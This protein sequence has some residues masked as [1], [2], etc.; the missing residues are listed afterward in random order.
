MNVQGAARTAS[1]NMGSSMIALARDLCAFRAAVVSDDNEKLFARI[2]QELPLTMTRP[3][4]RSASRIILSLSRVR[5]R[6]HNSN[7]IW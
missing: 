3:R 5:C 1:G 6:A 2:G 7:R 4:M